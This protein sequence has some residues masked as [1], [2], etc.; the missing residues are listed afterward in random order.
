MQEIL[1]DGMVFLKNKKEYL[2]LNSVLDYV[3]TWEQRM[4]TTPEASIL[5]ISKVQVLLFALFIL[6]QNNKSGRQNLEGLKST[7]DYLSQ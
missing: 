1:A 3:L 4:Q 7:A 6:H 2:Q 5:C